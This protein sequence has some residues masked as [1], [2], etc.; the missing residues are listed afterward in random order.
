MGW[1]QWGQSRGKGPAEGT[2][3]HPAGT[4]STRAAPCPALH[5]GPEALNQPFLQWE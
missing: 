3:A 2:G 1:T 4:I 5:Y